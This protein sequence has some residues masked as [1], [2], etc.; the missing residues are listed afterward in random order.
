MCVCVC[1][2]VYIS[3]SL[4]IYIY[5]I[6]TY[7]HTCTYLYLSLSI[8]I[9]I[10]ICIH[11]YTYRRLAWHWLRG[12]PQDPPLRLVHTHQLFRTPY[13]CFELATV[14]IDWWMCIDVRS[15]SNQCFRYLIQNRYT[16][17]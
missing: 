16:A 1:V 2:C 6:H 10:Y 13:T 8:Y 5:I 4:C 17:F 11:T 14:D 7:I 3:L 9:Y 15:N 12:E